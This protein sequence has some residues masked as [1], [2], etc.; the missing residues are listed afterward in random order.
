MLAK[1]AMDFGPQRRHNPSYP[2][3]ALIVSIAPFMLTQ[4]HL[5]VTLRR[6][7]ITEL[8]LSFASA[9]AMFRDISCKGF[10]ASPFLLFIFISFDV[11][12]SIV[13][14]CLHFF[15]F[16]LYLLFIIYCTEPHY[17]IRD[18]RTAHTLFC[19]PLTLHSHSTTWSIN[20]TI[21]VLSSSH[22]T[23]SSTPSHFINGHPHPRVSHP[24][25]IASRPK[26]RIYF[27]HPQPVSTHP[28]LRVLSHLVSRKLYPSRLILSFPSCIRD[29]SFFNLIFVG[30]AL[31]CPVL[32]SSTWNFS[33][34]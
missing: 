6:M 21:N 33:C 23:S 9:S 30:C 16:F 4:H 27:T 12:L 15:H 2:L 18:A 32:L 14:C 28:Y 1:F 26:S 29:V 13:L 20:A 17:C 25:G 3:A 24:N 19:N 10:R 31:C 7:C 34:F 5:R 22:F 11:M 8:V